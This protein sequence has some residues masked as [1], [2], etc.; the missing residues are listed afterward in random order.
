MLLEKGYGPDIMHLINVSDLV[1]IG[2]PPSDAIRLREYTAK[3]WP[4]ERRQ[5][6]KRPRDAETTGNSTIRSVAKSTPPSKRLHFEKHFND[7]GV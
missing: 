7:R 5:V 3:W 2:M 6:A 1:N 4:D